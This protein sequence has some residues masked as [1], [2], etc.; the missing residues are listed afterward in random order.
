[1]RRLI[2]YCRWELKN[3]VRAC[4]YFVAMVSC[5]GIAEAVYGNWQLDT[6][7]LFEMLILNYVQSLIQSIFL[8]ETKEYDN[9]TL[10]HRGCFLGVLFLSIT[11][12]TCRGFGW[13]S[14]CSIYAE[15]LMYVFMVIAYVVVWGIIQLS[16]YYDTKDLNEELEKF[17]Q[18]NQEEECVYEEGN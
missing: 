9:K 10:L 2:K 3:E 1:M 13:F 12:L 16:R 8:D 7:V 6:K 11:V 4:G 5:Y 14:D 17:K 15:I 18:N